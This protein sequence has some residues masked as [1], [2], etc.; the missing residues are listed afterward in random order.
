M[1]PDLT[2]WFNKYRDA[3]LAGPEAIAELYYEPC[4]N[5]RM[6]VRLNHTRHDTA[7][8]FQNVLAKY[9]AQ[10]FHHGEIVAMET[11][12][13]GS[14]SMLATVRW[15]YKNADNETLWEWTFT[16]I[17]YDADGDWKILLNTLHES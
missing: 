5:A 16:Y 13:L 11:R 10:G 14:K 4:L 17:L 6:G 1:E 3:F 9:R 8:F 7:E 2:E 15:A 12:S